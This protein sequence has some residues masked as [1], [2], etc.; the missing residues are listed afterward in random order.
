MDMIVC[1]RG[2]LN[3]ASDAVRRNLVV[4]RMNA[5]K[6][7]SGSAY[8]C[9]HPRHNFL[10]VQLQPKLELPG[11]VRGSRAAVVASVAGALIEV[12]N[13]VDERRRGGF[14]KPVKEVESFRDQ[15][16]PDPLAKW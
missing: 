9:V 10:E 7:R 13:V 5:N 4:P 11:I 12:A 6:R 14:V 3:K 1:G 15:L 2:W 16:Q 8:I